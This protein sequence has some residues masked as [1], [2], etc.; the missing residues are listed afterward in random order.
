MKRIVMLVVATVF[1][2]AAAWA[3]TCRDSRHVRA[4]SKFSDIS[5]P[6]CS[7]LHQ[8]ETCRSGVNPTS[9]AEI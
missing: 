7:P 1:V 2:V 6:Q 5:C 8:I 3:Q 9:P 4:R